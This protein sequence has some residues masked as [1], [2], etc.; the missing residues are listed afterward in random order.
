M[1]LFTDYEVDGFFDECSRER[2]TRSPFVAV[3]SRRHSPR[4]GDGAATALLP[5][6]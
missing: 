3:P 1:A 5:L 2:A 4:T 6:R